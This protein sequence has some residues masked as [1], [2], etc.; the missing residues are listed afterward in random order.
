MHVHL[1]ING[2]FFKYIHR[3]TNYALTIEQRFAQNQYVSRVHE[4][5]FAWYSKCGGENA[6]LDVVVS[7]KD[8]KGQIIYSPEPLHLV[9][10]LVYSDESPT[11]FMPLCPLKERRTSTTSR[12][13]LYRALRPEPV[14]GPDKTIAPF[15]FR[16]EEVSFHHPNHSGFKLKVSCPSNCPRV[17]HPGILRENI[18]VL[19]KPKHE[20]TPSLVNKGII[21]DGGKTPSVVN[22]QN[23]GPIAV[24]PVEKL[25][26]G[27]LTNDNKCRSCSKI[28]SKTEFLSLASHEES[29]HIVI[30]LLPFINHASKDV[31][32]LLRSSAPGRKGRKIRT[33]IKNSNFQTPSLASQTTTI[34]DTNISSIK[35]HKIRFP[36]SVKS[37]KAPI[38]ECNETNNPYTKAMQM[39][40][41]LKEGKITQRKYE[42]INSEQ[43]TTLIT[44]KPD[45][46]NSSTSSFKIGLVTN[47]KKRKASSDLF[48]VSPIRYQRPSKVL[49]MNTTYSDEKGT[50]WTSNIEGMQDITLASTPS[51]LATCGGSTSSL[52]L[53]FIQTPKSTTSTDGIEPISY[54]SSNFESALPELCFSRKSIDGSA[55]L[56]PPASYDEF[57][58]EAFHGIS[59]MIFD[60]LLE[61]HSKVA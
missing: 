11:P 59:E 19:S 35:P 52:S 18:I 28:I 60:E 13:T 43:A 15:C 7:M 51:S 12:K 57:S 54:P 16:I 21:Q 30:N 53:H 36:D 24:I 5:E 49:S 4:F 9:T 61:V 55:N 31:K 3:V 8:D 1:F 10:E 46:E 37:V 14:L 38:V 41:S 34:V 6:G 27:L 39:P 29:C 33:S 58:A 50:Q 20:N 17:V 32:S 45:V 56:E 23:D 40:T 26:N 47:K 42:H 2:L 22:F 25:I 48:D 44:D